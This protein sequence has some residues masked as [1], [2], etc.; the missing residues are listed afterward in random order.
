MLQVVTTT[1]ASSCSKKG[2]F[3][4][5][6]KFF[7]WIEPGGDA[8]H[9]ACV[10]KLLEMKTN[11]EKLKNKVREDFSVFALHWKQALVENFVHILTY[12]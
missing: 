2:L 4:S 1:L 5:T 9:T 11:N 3:L 6:Q 8:S 12:P 7:N 10:G